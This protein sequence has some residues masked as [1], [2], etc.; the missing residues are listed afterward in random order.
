MAV[1][2]CNLLLRLID[3]IHFNLYIRQQ[4]QRRLKRSR[5]YDFIS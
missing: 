5:L 1:N 2:L 3:L 4:S